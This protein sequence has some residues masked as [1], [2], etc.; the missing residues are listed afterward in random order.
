MENERIRCRKCRSVLLSET[1]LC[2]LDAHGKEYHD[3]VVDETNNP[4]C[5]CPSLME[6]SCLYLSEESFPDFVLQAIEELFQVTPQS[7]WTKGKVYCPACQAR[8]GS[9][10]FVSGSQC[11]CGSHVLP[12]AHIL[13][14]KVD[15]MKVNELLPHPVSFPNQSVVLCASTL[16]LDESSQVSP[17]EA[18]DVKE[19]A[20]TVVPRNFTDLQPTD[21]PP[22]DTCLGR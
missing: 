11:A 2:V 1:K 12:Q 9:F 17:S 22:E 20:A 5:T 4:E 7:S 13:K 14:S 15:W 21:V 16:P 10:N 18:S 19:G 6:H 8:L 3:T